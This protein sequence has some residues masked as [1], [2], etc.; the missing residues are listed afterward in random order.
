MTYRVLGY[1]ENQEPEDI[2]IKQVST[3]KRIG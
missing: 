3:Y 2:D 1:E